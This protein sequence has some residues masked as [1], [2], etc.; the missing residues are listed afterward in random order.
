MKMHIRVISKR[1]RL[2]FLI[3][4]L[5]MS[6]FLMVRSTLPTNRDDST[7]TII[8]VG[9]SPFVLTN[10]EKQNNVASET[11]TDLEML[12]ILE[13]SI[14]KIP[15]PAPVPYLDVHTKIWNKTFGGSSY[16]DGYSI[17]EVS[18][19]GFAIAGSTAS[20]GVGYE[21]F[22]LLRTDKD[23]N[24]L[25]NQT[26]GV[27]TQFAE[28]YSIIECS[29]GGFIM[30]G[31]ITDFPSYP[32]D[33]WVIRTDA[34]GYVTWDRTF[35]GTSIDVAYQIIEVS[36]G[37]FAVVGTTYSFGAGGSDM[38]L[39]RIDE[40]GNHLWNETYGD[41][42][43]DTCVSLVECSSGGFALAGCTEN[44]GAV[45]YD[46]LLV[47]TDAGGHQQ[48]QR[49][50]SRVDEEDMYTESSL[51]E[52]SDGGFVLTGYT[53]NLG[54][55]GDMW[56]VRT[57]QN[58]NHLWN[59]TYGGID[60][61][62]AYSIIECSEGGFAFIGET[63]SFGAGD[64]DFF[65]VRIDAYGNQLWNQTYGGS[66]SE[67]Y[68]TDLVECSDGGFIFTG[69]TTSFGAGQS[70][71][72]LVR[73]SGPPHWMETPA[74][75]IWELGVDGEYNLNAS[76]YPSIDQWW[77]N[78]TVDFS[79][80]TNGIVRNASSLSTGWYGLQVWVNNTVSDVQSANFTITVLDTLPPSWQPTPSNQNN[81]L[82]TPFYYDLNASDPSGVDSWWINDTTNFDIDINGAISNTSILAIGS[83]GLRVWVNDTNN[84]V[85]SSDFQITVEDTTAPA[86]IETPTN[87]VIEFGEHLVYDLNATDISGLSHW[88]VDDNVRF[89]IDWTGRLRNNT[90][91]SPS[92]YGVSVYVNDTYGNIRSANILVT[93]QD[94]T[95]PSW[96]ETPT[97]Q[98]L[99]YGETLQYQLNATDLS[100]ID[101]WTLND[102][103]HF[104]I[105]NVGFL[106]SSTTLSPGSYSLSITAYD[107]YDNYI[108]ATIMI[109]VEGGITLP[110]VELLLLVG[111][112][113]VAIIIVAIT[114]RWY[115]RRPK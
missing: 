9:N 77:I 82:G 2:V 18:T 48:W 3:T 104:S 110:P 58:G 40:A 11:S 96:L 91:I 94:T 24:Y 87:Q 103:I 12:L 99:Q 27:P 19:G 100:G 37:G 42:G 1:L 47:R 71:V 83:Y 65:L 36:A 79:I 30:A 106:T 43:Y 61:E 44:Y 41:T 35:G 114:Y 101:H 72:M 49:I 109:T 69:S 31:R 76:A 111:G 92:D 89:N 8:S 97:D 86:W 53:Y 56:V 5:A 23:G 17:I 108:T 60:W 75:Q 25:W 107:P 29:D 45:N 26:Y 102:T 59:Q 14:T 33:I 22:L 95:A 112:V 7:P 51:V 67:G 39:I 113:V 46:L 55:G 63:L 10:Q 70:D 57:D 68:P 4:I 62:C 90:I 52:C 38:L 85:T 73:V 32:D 15:Q 98:V 78:N 13:K 34:D 28:A 50:Y 64:F 115:K 84:W 54:N 6:V 20:V 21:N 80:D 88:W 16:D 105:N 93:V 74:S 81:E 66:E